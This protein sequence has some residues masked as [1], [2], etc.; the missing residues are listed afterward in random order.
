MDNGFFLITGTSRGIGKV[1]AQK[2][3][4]E[5]NTILG[6][7]RNR[8][9]TLKSK[10]YYHLSFDLTDT[11][12][13]GQIMVQVNEIVEK[14]NFEFVCLVN[15]ASAVEPIGPIEKCPADEVEAH[16]QAMS[17]PWQTFSSRRTRMASC[18]NRAK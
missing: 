3:L 18:R 5:G 16:E 17:L 2:I 13:I 10:N 11:S 1:L 4:E 6:V 14:Q 9:E 8:S 12:Q 15:N 7:S